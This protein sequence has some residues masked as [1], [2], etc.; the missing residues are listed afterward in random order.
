MA[1]PT[2]TPSAM[3]S[4]ATPMPAPI[5]PP[6]AIPTPRHFFCSGFSDSFMASPE[7]GPGWTLARWRNEGNNVRSSELPTGGAHGAPHHSHDGNGS[8]FLPLPFPADHPPNEGKT[9]AQRK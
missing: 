8:P 6:S 4:I 3:L 2:P 9:A 5:A 1:I 7:H